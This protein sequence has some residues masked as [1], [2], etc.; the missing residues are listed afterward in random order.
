MLVM[1]LEWLVGRYTL[2][3]RGLL[4]RVMTYSPI[5]SYTYLLS[6]HGPLSDPWRSPEQSIEIC[7]DQGTGEKSGVNYRKLL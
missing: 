2:V 4:P 3:L 6:E 1:S 7:V 5:D